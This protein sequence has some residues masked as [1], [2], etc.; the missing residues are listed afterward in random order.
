MS[1]RHR[2]HI[3]RDQVIYIFFNLEHNLQIFGRPKIYSR[4]R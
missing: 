4:F 2:D 3:I 1:G